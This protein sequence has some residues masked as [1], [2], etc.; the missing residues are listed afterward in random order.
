[1]ANRSSLITIVV[2]LLLFFIIILDV[3][4]RILGFTTS[5]VRP[6][7]FIFNVVLT[8][9]VLVPNSPMELLSVIS[10]IATKL[11]PGPIYSKL[12]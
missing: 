2:L 3:K 4:F 5:N 8:K 11:L 6:L 10:H 1:M 7:K 9:Q 12:P